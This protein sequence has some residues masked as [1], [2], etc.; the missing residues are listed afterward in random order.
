MET[1]TEERTEKLTGQIL[2]MQGNLHRIRSIANLMRNSMRLQV[3]TNLS[4]DEKWEMM[5]SVY[6]C[7]NEIYDIA[8]ISD[9]DRSDFRRWGSDE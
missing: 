7:A 2:I 8:E 1:K 4:E 9:P 6:H 3:E 5:W